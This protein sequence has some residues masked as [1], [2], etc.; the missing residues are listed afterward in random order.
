MST[1]ELTTDRL[2]RIQAGC[3][4]QSGKAKDSAEKRLERQEEMKHLISR[5]VAWERDGTV[6][7]IPDSLTTYGDAAEFK[8]QGYAK[9]GTP[10]EAYEAQIR[11][12]QDESAVRCTDTPTQDSSDDPNDFGVFINSVG[13]M[14]Q[15]KP[16]DGQTRGAQ[17]RQR[18]RLTEGATSVDANTGC[19]PHLV[20]S[21]DIDQSAIAASTQPAS[22]NAEVDLSITTE[23]PIPKVILGNDDSRQIRSATSGHCMTC[24]PWRAIGALTPDGTNGNSPNAWGTATKIGPR[25][26]LTAA[27]AVHTGGSGGSWLWR[28]WWPGQDGMNQF[29]NGGDPSPNGVYNIEWYWVPS[30]WLNNGWRTRDYAVLILY[31]SPQAVSLGWFGYNVDLTLA[32]TSAWNFGYPLGGNTCDNSLLANKS[33]QQSLWGHSAKITRTTV[34]YVFYKHDTQNGHSG[35]PVYQINNGNRQIVAVHQGGFTAVENR[36]VKI[37]SSVFDNISAV[38]GLWPSEY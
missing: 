26:L 13:E 25:H 24:Y 18:A 20:D 11:A 12:G 31:D 38:I 10:K 6:P 16:I 22:S 30:R 32:N 37:R 33:C 1:N 7:T 35:S 29:L 4:G 28:D 2:I 21:G 8:F 27:H 23:Q 5:R 9:L 36:G 34:N 17:L 15:W 14:W 19:D 3:G